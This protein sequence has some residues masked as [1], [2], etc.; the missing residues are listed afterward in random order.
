MNILVTGAAGYIGRHVVRELVGQ[1]HA[2]TACDITFKGVDERARFCETQIFSR[3]DDIFEKTGRPELLIHLAWKNGFVHNSPAHME[4]L[5]DHIIFLRNMA[6]AGCKKIAVMGSM[7]EVGYY[8]G[9]IDENTPCAPLSQYGIAKNALR[10]SMLLAS[11]E[12]DFSLYW[13]RAYYIY[14]DDAHGSSIFAK[15]TQAAA[16]GKKE[17][18]FTSGQNKYDF[19][20][21]RKLARLIAAASTQEEITGIINVCSGKPVSLAEQV[22]QYIQKNGF[23]IKLQYGAFPDRP[24]DSP[25]VWGNSEK[26]ERIMAGGAL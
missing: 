16:D 9:A 14:G 13:L 1:G 20:S 12:L 4:N 19:I 10:Q 21:V 11:R 2:V 17:F 5:S 25:A 15:I 22:E 6:A 23:D 3:K 7:H 24:Y 26:I 18:P 8:E